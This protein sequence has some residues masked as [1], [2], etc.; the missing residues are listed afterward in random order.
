MLLA[1]LVTEACISVVSAA[2]SL[3]VDRRFAA[4]CSCPES[5][6]PKPRASW[7]RAWA[8]DCCLAAWPLRARFVVAMQNLLTNHSSAIH[9]HDETAT[10]LCHRGHV[11]C[12]LLQH[13][14]GRW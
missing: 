6:A 5:S 2:R 13:D 4:I 7:P 9:Q 14:L 1:T 11:A 10:D 8:G 3:S 12:C